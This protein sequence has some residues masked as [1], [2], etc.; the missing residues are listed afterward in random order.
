[1][2][3]PICVVGAGRVGSALAARLRDRGVAVRT[4]AGR[5]LET[6]GAELV[7]LCVPDGAIAEVAQQIEPGPWVAHV[8]GAT[9]LVAL[10]PHRRRFSIH[11][12]QTFTHARGPE[13]FDGAWAA[14]TAETDEARAHALE[15]ARILGLE[16]FHLADADRPL[17]HAGAVVASNY[18]VTLHEA[19]AALVAAAGAPPEALVPLMQRTIE[20]GFELTGPIAR[21]DWETVE[22]HLRAIHAQVPAIEP[23]YRALAEVTRA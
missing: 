3:E 14:V 13:Q 12:L 5:G 21:G 20:N 2:L 7:L 1:M 15:L 6:E 19:A 17:Y 4:R 16:P 11:P 23:M 18:L 22:A 8:S 10:E 9:P